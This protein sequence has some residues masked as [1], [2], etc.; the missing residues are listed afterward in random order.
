MKH[1]SYEESPALYTKILYFFK[2]YYVTI[3]KIL[4]KEYQLQNVSEHV[5]KF[6]RH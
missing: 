5:I 1:D 6:F 4:Y 2:K 3:V